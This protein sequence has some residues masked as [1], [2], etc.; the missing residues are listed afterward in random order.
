[1]TSVRE[2]HSMFI[3]HRETAEG[4]YRGKILTVDAY[5]L[6]AGESVYSTPIVVASDAPDGE[7]L[8]IFVLPFGERS[9][10]SFAHLR[11]VQPGQR[12]RVSGECRMFSDD[13]NV[14]VFKDCR[15]IAP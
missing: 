11:T 5:A 9:R 13:G 6:S 10:A 12:I 15:L 4:T 14:L 7:K 3:Q 1:M 8:A 2:I